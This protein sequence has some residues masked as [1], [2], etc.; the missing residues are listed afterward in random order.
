MKR[1]AIA[2][3]AG[4][5]GLALLRALPGAAQPSKLALTV[6]L[7]EEGCPS[8]GKDSGLLAGMGA[9]EV[10]CVSTMEG[11]ACDVLI[12]FSVADAVPAH[13]QYCVEQGCA[14]VVGVTGLREEEKQALTSASRSIPVLYAANMSVGVSVLMALVEQATR[15]L[16]GS[17][18]EIVE[19]HHRHKKDSPSGTALSLGEI[20]ARARGVA[21][22][23]SAVYDRH[24]RKTARS[25][26]DIGFA[27][28]RGGDNVG[29]HT[30]LFMDDGERIEITHRASD[31]HIF[32]RGALQAASWI[33][34]QKAGLYGMRDLLKV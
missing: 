8:L 1:V 28:L 9:N 22:T 5:M 10:R 17:D 2:G 27:S 11:L 24:G 21:L 3:A 32:A 33:I 7:V 12:D 31:R 30:V 18:V 34:D 6:A 13:A 26:Q 4:K 20:V 25:R 15:A 14:M 23:K 19:A 29:E 16:P